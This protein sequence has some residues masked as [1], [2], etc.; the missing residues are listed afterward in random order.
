MSDQNDVNNTQ[1]LDQLKANL[2]A[3]RDGLAELEKKEHQLKQLLVKGKV[4]EIQ[5]LDDYRLTLQKKLER[6]KQERSRLLPEGMGLRQYL[7]DNT[8]LDQRMEMTQLLEAVTGSL[9]HLQSIQDVNRNLLEDR[10]RH[11]REVI[12]AF[13]PS[14]STYDDSGQVNQSYGETFNINKNC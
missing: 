10:L 11:S 2:Q 1:N 4:E 5:Q 13:M 7:Q 8:P 3:S 6:L 12:E 14:A 9:Y